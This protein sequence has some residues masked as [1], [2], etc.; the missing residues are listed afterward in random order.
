MGVLS[1]E[2]ER[3]RRF[4]NFLDSSHKYICN[5]TSSLDT[6]INTDCTKKTLFPPSW[7]RKKYVAF[8]LQLLLI[9]LE[10]EKLLGQR[11]RKVRQDVVTGI[12]FLFMAF[13][14]SNFRGGNLSCTLLGVC[15]MA[16]RLVGLLKRAKL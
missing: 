1:R 10:E 13:T 15:V 2:S 14:S 12:V 3:Q 4:D 8:V 11:A 9:H 6:F 5:E 7:Q 16:V